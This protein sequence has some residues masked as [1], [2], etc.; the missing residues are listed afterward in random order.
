MIRSIQVLSTSAAMAFALG[1]ATAEEA[2]GFL[3]GLSYYGD[4]R[5]RFEADYDS[6]R[7]D[8]TMRNDR[9][10]GR[11]RFRFG[12]NYEFD[13]QWKAG[14]RVRT[15]SHRSQQSPH[16]TFVTD[17]G[18]TD[19]LEFVVDK[20]F[21]AYQDD[22][23]NIWVGRNAFPF[24]KQHELFWD[25]D[26]TPT[27]VAASSTHQ[28]AGGDLTGTV[29]GFYLPD[30]GH[31]VHQPMVAGQT[32][33][34]K[35]CGNI[36]LTVA[37]GFF[38]FFAESEPSRYLLN[39]NGMRDYAIGS[40]QTRLSSDVNGLPVTLGADLYKNFEDYSVGE[41]DPFITPANKD[42]DF[43]YVLSAQ[44]G[45]IAE[46]GDWL[47]AYYYAYIETFAVN[48]SYS[49]DDWMR[50]GNGPQTR[51]SDF[52]GHEIRFA[53]ALRDNLNIMARWYSTESINTREDGKRFRVDLNWKF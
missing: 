45:S 15:G 50:W 26:V 1:S 49:E 43:G 39:G 53:Y 3:D 20:Y 48:S 17:D 23:W 11:V 52:K 42:D 25:D 9:N 10:R 40:F 41:G 24:W 5:L 4:L 12:L 32:K 37:P 22:D 6:R 16:L 44:V 8:G 47:F 2:V 14:V 51:S 34:T 21:L 38:Y 36:E 35:S 29:G 46:Q 7:P 18:P 33:F 13:S 19:D 28:W 31:E 30:G 27:G